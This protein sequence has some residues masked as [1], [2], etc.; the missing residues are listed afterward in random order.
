MLNHYLNVKELIQEWG[1]C[2]LDSLSHFGS[3]DAKENKSS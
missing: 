1:V 2:I 3:Q